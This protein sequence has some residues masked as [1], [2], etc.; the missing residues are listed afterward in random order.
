MSLKTTVQRIAYGAGMF[1]ATMTMLSCGGGGGGDPLA[2]FKSQALTWQACDPALLEAPLFNDWLK[3]LGT[4][5]LC[6][7]MRVPLDYASPT[8]GEAV[9]ALLKVSAEQPQRRLGAMML[10]PGGPGHDGLSLSVVFGTLWGNA[11]PTSSTGAKYKELSQRYD[12]VGFSPRG[13][14][15][16]TRLTCTSSEQLRFVTNLVDD[17]SPE[18]M[19]NILYNARLTAE[20]CLKNPLT[21]YI[22]SEATARD[23]DLMRHLLGAEKFNYLGISYGTWLGTWYA[24]LFPQR[25]GRMLL[26]GNT[27]ATARLNDTLLP[28]E[29]GMQRVV[30]QVWAP[31]AARHPARFNLGDTDEAVR[32][33]FRSL[34]GSMRDAT[35]KSLQAMIAVSDLADSALLTL[36]AAQVLQGLIEAYP[37]GSETAI[38]GRIATANFVSSASLNEQARSL[39]QTLNADY[40]A[41]FRKETATVNL[42]SEDA[43]FWA[44]QCNDTGTT[45]D[46]A[47]W[48]QASRLNASLYSLFGAFNAMNPCLY[49]GGPIIKKPASELAAQAGGIVLLQSQL[50]PFTT[51]EGALKSLAVLPNASMIL[52]ENEYQHSIGIPYGTD[53][54]DLPIAEYFL[55]GTQPPRTTN[56]AGKSLAADRLTGL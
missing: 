41:K 28:M 3:Q 48:S 43:V 42:S 46:A 29:M 10:N 50:D 15:A 54:V 27:D 12:L 38:L 20:A 19:G 37:T 49:W 33:V 55:N 22:N 31:Y 5:A 17:G 40:F 52:I 56:C 1:A 30:D 6:A 14:G 26:I 23:M 25:V 39:A 35:V 53:C 45:F 47:S 32:Q 24:S 34:H 8:Q 13:T 51:L 11:S 21:P 4:R 18:N 44:I 2:S 7:N 36:R 9:V 16:S